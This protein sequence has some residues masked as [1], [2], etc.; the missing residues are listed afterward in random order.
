MAE[1]L[2]RDEARERARLLRVH[3]YDVRLDLTS[4]ITDSPTFRSTSVVQFDCNEP[5]ASTHVDITAD[6]IVEASLN[7]TA[8]SLDSFTGRRLTLDGLAADNV[9][10]IVADCVYM[11]TGEGLHR[12]TDPVDK[13][14]YLYTQFETFDAHRM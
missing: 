2:T 7:G 12:F 10:R 14:T 6:T 11:R 8:L 4:A 3:S 1:N 9:L 5:G 13:E